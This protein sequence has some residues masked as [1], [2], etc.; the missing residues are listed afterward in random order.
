[1]E[2]FKFRDKMYFAE[3]KGESI[4]VFRNGSMKT[5]KK[6]KGKVY[7]SLTP[8]SSNSTDKARPLNGRAVQNGQNIIPNVFAKNRNAAHV[9][10]RA[11]LFCFLLGLFTLRT[12]G[13]KL[14][15]GGLCVCVCVCVCVVNRHGCSVLTD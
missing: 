7:T 4:S 6:Q 1:M 3:V 5:Q 9:V 10:C 13:Y 8:W 15:L 2:A 14:T 12:A 11:I